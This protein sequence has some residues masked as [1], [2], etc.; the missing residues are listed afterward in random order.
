M[1]IKGTCS[2]YCQTSHSQ[3]LGQCVSHHFMLWYPEDILFGSV[4]RDR[5]LDGLDARLR[6]RPELGPS[7]FRC[8]LRLFS[9]AIFALEI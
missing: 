5:C 9:K 1:A 3:C 8:Y 7:A 6:P 2:V 4:D